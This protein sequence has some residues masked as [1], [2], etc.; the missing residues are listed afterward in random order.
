MFLQKKRNVKKKWRLDNFFDNETEKN[1]L[2]P[3]SF[4]WL[5]FSCRGVVTEFDEETYMFIT[6]SDLKDVHS[7][8]Q[9]NEIRNSEKFAN[10]SLHPKAIKLMQARHIPVWSPSSGTQKRT[11][12]CAFTFLKRFNWFRVLRNI[13]GLRGRNRFG[14]RD[15]EFRQLW[16]RWRWVR[17][18]G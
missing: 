8:E 1:I 2:G 3:I 9:F 10:R 16:R 18:W 6:V 12:Q 11:T 5:H 13:R 15:L 7:L 4:R 14:L 17:G